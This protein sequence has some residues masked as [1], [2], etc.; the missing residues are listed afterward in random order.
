M[1]VQFRKMIG[2]L[3]LIGV[4]LAFS[5]PAY[6][7]SGDTLIVSYATAH[8]NYTP[9]SVQGV[10]V[11]PSGTV[12]TTSPLN[13]YARDK[14]IIIDPEEG[15]YTAYF[16]ALISF[17]PRTCYIVGGIDANLCKQPGLI[18]PFTPQESHI[19]GFD[20]SK[21]VKIGD[22]TLPVASFEIF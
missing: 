6:S 20:Q 13:P 4:L 22:K 9:G 8:M 3:S 5:T 19:Q 16:Q 2:L 21:S 14:I 10:L 15:N 7:L 11:A 1:F 18:I 12:W 17:R